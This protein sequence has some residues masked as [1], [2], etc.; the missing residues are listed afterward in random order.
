MA[1]PNATTG[2]SEYIAQ[3]ASKLPP[4]MQARLLF[5][6]NVQRAHFN[7]GVMHIPSARDL[8]ENAYRI[9]QKGDEPDI[10]HLLLLFT[11]FCG[12]AL[13]WTPQLLK[14]LNATEPEAKTAGSEYLQLAY[15]IM[16][17]DSKPVEPSTIALVGLSNLGSIL[18]DIRGPSMNAV[19]MR[20]KAVA[21]ARAMQL[22][23]LDT[24]QSQLERSKKGFSHI[25]L[26]VQRRSWWSLVASDW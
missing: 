15:N 14:S 22:D 13:T 12:S 5:N 16:E 21:M 7:Y 18:V 11:I 1:S 25:E 19:T 17:N 26:E 23:R 24:E 8:L 6:H 4:L 10:A 2:P 9:M 3:V 20:L